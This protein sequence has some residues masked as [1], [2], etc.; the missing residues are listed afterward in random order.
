MSE[1][2]ARVT[3]LS[4]ET[5]PDIGEL[6][7]AFASVRTQNARAIGATAAAHGIS[8]TDLRAVAFVSMAGGATPKQVA[9]HL[10]LTTGALTTLVDR[11]ERAA[12][13][14]RTANPNDRRSLL[15]RLTPQGSAVMVELNDFY[16]DAFSHTFD[17]EEIPRMR[18]AFLALAEALKRVADSRGSVAGAAAE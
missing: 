4:G 10:G 16:R 11:L 12:F 8:A 6:V 2:L 1:S 14:T 15:L 13:V 9:E 7:L 18:E 3:A 17:E 5:A